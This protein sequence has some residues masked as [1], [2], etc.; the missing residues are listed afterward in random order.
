MEPP[1]INMTAAKKTSPTRT[2]GA[3]RSDVTRHRSLRPAAQLTPAGCTV[4]AVGPAHSRAVPSFSPGWDHARHSIFLLFR[5]AA[6]RLFDVPIFVA[7][8]FASGAAEAIVGIRGMLFTGHS[9]G[10]SSVGSGR[11][12]HIYNRRLSWPILQDPYSIWAVRSPSA[13]GTPSCGVTSQ[14]KWSGTNPVPR[15]P[16]TQ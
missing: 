1:N 15:S 13:T 10:G 4:L 8:R 16:A 3:A 12:G 5:K 14:L 11:D 9:T 2:R 7:G 6:C